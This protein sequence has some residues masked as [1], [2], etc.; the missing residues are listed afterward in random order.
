MNVVANLF[1]DTVVRKWYY[2]PYRTTIW[3]VIWFPPRIQIEILCWIRSTARMYMTSALQKISDIKH[4]PN[5]TFRDT[6][7]DRVTIVSSLMSVVTM[8]LRSL[9]ISA[10]LLAPHVFGFQ[11]IVSH[12]G[13]A[14][15]NHLTNLH[16][17]SAG[18]TTDE[19]AKDRRSFL[20][21]SSAFA[22]S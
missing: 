17:A 9:L 22:A 8:M 16:A 10:C 3:I 18:T 11:S 20:L 13:V 21:S 12:N 15:H 5:P 2:V 1:L 4:Q 7:F 14:K 19:N 6:D